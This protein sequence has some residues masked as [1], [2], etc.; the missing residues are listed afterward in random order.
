MMSQKSNWLCGRIEAVRRRTTSADAS[1]ILMM[2][3]GR[4]HDRLRRSC[5]P[6]SLRKAITEPVNVMAPMATPR[7]ISIRLACGCGRARRCRR[8]PGRRT[9]PPPPA[10]PPCRRANGRPRPVPA[11][12]S[13]ARAGRSPRR[14]CRRSRCRRR[15][16]TQPTEPAGGCDPSVV[17]T[18]IAM[19]T[20]PKKLPR[21]A[22]LRARKSAQRQ[23]EEDAGD[24]IEKR[25][26]DWRS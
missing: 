13:S 19:P 12:R 8:P 23:D 7:D 2:W 18:A 5:A 21:P 14:S 6:E 20:M 25:R 3:R 11:S 26:R 1:A 15:P 22:G 16:S 4:Q 9:R 10:P 24:E 17:S